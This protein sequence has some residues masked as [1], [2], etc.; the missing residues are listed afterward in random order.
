MGQFSVQS[1]VMLT[2]FVLFLPLFPTCFSLNLYK[3]SEYSEYNDEIVVE[4]S[5]HS[6]HSDMVVISQTPEPIMTTSGD[7]MELSDMVETETTG[8]LN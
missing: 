7:T 1:E 3:L 2:I 6:G 5:T 4:D 8:I